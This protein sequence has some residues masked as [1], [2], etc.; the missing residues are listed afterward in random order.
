MPIVS[1]RTLKPGEKQGGWIGKLVPVNPPAQEPE[2]TAPPAP[3]P[4][5]P[6]SPPEPAAEGER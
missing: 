5:D 1:H 6:P 3:A 2:P 4:A